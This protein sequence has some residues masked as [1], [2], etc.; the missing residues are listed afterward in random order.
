MTALRITLPLA[1]ALMSGSAVAADGKASFQR[2]KSTGLSC[3][4]A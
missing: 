1:L 4:A 3:P 2:S